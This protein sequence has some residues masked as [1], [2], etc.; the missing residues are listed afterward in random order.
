MVCENIIYFMNRIGFA[1]LKLGTGKGCGG[2]GVRGCVRGISR[3]LNEDPSKVKKE[4]KRD[5]EYIYA[6]NI[7]PPSCSI[8]LPIIIGSFDISLLI[9]SIVIFSHS[10]TKTSL[11]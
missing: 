5:L 4:K 2:G 1:K 9:S 8:H 3:L 11:I 7:S 6:S 10:S